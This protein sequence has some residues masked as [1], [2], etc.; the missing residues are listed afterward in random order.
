M[1]WPQSNRRPSQA[2]SATIH[3]TDEALKNLGLSLMKLNAARWFFTETV[4]VEKTA[5]RSIPIWRLKSMFDGSAH[6]LSV[7]LE[8]A[9]REEESR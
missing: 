3:Q 1:S 8:Y 6:S 5:V 7:T 9:I 4:W 2:R